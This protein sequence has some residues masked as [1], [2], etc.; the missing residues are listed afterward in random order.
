MKRYLFK[1]DVVILLNFIILIMLTE[2]EYIEIN[3]G[4]I[5]IFYMIIEYIFI[6]T[7]I[8]LFIYNIHIV[9]SDI[10]ISIFRFNLYKYFIIENL[11]YMCLFG[12]IYI[13]FQKNTVYIFSIKE[14][15]FS[16]LNFNLIYKKG[17]Y[18]ELSEYTIIPL[19]KMNL[20]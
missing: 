3:I 11:I 8:F 9:F 4:I 6:I 7:L 19:D 5:H 10:N 17:L 18:K 16:F 12:T 20:I 14:A 1:Y 2:K 13:L 15:F